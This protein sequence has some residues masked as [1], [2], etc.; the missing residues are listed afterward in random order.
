MA[1]ERYGRGMEDWVGLASGQEVLKN[2]NLLLIPG[3][4]TGTDQPL[5]Y[6]LY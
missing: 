3:F 2:R 6:L 5:A 1:G 4:G